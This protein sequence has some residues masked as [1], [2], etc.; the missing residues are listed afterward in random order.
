MAFKNNMIWWSGRYTGDAAFFTDRPDGHGTY[1][2]DGFTKYSGEWKNGNFHGF[3]TYYWNEK[4]YVEGYFSHGAITRG[5]VV[6]ASGN[7]V[8]GKMSGRDGKFALDG[9]CMC[10]E[11]YSSHSYPVLY[12]HGRFVKKL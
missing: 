10:Q 8:S 5:T 11:P 12:D 6:F 2:I 4:E 9:E 3:G 1:S 7:R